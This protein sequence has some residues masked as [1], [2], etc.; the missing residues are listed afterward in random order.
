MRVLIITFS[1]I[2]FLSACQNNPTPE[3]P[4]L[5]NIPKEVAQEWV[6]AFYSDDFSKAVV[7]GTETT[8]M[9]I[10]SVK[11]EMQVNAI[12]IPFKISEMNCEIVLDSAL[13]TYVYL[14]EGERYDEYVTLLKLNGQWLVNES[15]ENTEEIEQDFEKLKEEMKKMMEEETKE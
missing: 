1:F 13:C 7:L 5:P 14:E 12:S 3:E 11:K 9:M 6:E 4:S 15:W 2:V 8:R 10:D